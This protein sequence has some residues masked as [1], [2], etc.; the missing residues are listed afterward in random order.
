MAVPYAT[1]HDRVRAVAH[2]VTALGSRLTKTA[3][4]AA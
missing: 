1:V 2:A 4:V 3:L